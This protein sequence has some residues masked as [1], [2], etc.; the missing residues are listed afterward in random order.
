MK[1]IKSRLP[2]M[3]LALIGAIYYGKKIDLN[4]QNN[5]TTIT[6]KFGHDMPTGTPLHDGAL[7]FKRLI[8]TESNGEIKIE[9]LASQSLGTDVQM[10]QMV[11]KGEIAFALPPTSKITALSPE[12]S[13]LDIPYL[14]K[15]RKA[16]YTAVDGEFGKYIFKGLTDIGLVPLSLWESGYKSFTANRP[17][18]SPKNFRGLR[19]RVMNSPT[20]KSQSIALNSFPT[21]IDFHKISDSIKNDIIDI[22]ENSLA[23]IY[24]LKIH[25]M[26][27]HITYS[28]HGFIG[29][30]LITSQSV[31]NTLSTRHREIIYKA[32]KD[33]TQFQREQAKAFDQK[34]LTLIEKSQNKIHKLDD[35]EKQE[36]IKSFAPIY[37]QNRNV[38]KKFTDHLNS[39]VLPYLEEFA[40]IGLNLSFSYHSFASALSIKM[41]AELAIEEINKRNG[42]NGK[43]LIL[44]TYT[45]DG[46]PKVGTYNLENFASDNSILAFLGGMHSPVILHERKKINE[47]KIPYLIPWAAATPIISKDNPYIFRFSVRDSDAGET[48]VKQATR[49]GSKIF[50]LLENTGWG[51]SNEK[52]I[53]QA[54]T[55]LK[56]G[57]IVGTQWFDWGK[58]NF[59]DT[60]KNIAESGAQTLIFVGNAPEGSHLVKQ[61]A[62]SKKKTPIL[63]HWGITGGRFWQNTQ[64]E[65]TVVDLNFL[66]T[67]YLPN[68]IS[69]PEFKKMFK[70]YKE[71]YGIKDNDHI[72]AFY[73]T[74]HTY[75]LIHLLEQ[76]IK[77]GNS[78]D[79]EVITEQLRKIKNFN[80]ITKNFKNIFSK[81]DRMQEALD[82]SDLSIGRFDQRGNIQ[83]VN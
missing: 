12:L 57:T 8:E 49:S 59:E 38:L 71:K 40:A 33:S 41:G 22:Q 25:D 66:V 14:F 64:Q 79:P 3:I 35:H 30:V 21:L 15:D 82:G 46:F 9:I 44:Q 24:S 18:T 70:N 83:L 37:Y 50:L 19:F 16:L 77:N 26:H 62:H 54:I 72:P 20:L 27:Q 28:N 13:L 31:L 53:N 17:L 68:N 7:E 23:S 10:T 61:M 55:R 45:H 29:Q 2:L 42:I 67:K 5:Q 81:P 4:N 39:L 78:F 36:F 63:S 60:L 48:L 6:L 34:L 69:K 11:Q 65:L 51:K 80:G 1:K 76:A 74:V 47:L 52:S 43:K 56:K 32:V 58:K 73:G 75:E